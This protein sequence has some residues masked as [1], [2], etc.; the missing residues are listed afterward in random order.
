MT[1]SRGV[2]FYLYRRSFNQI[3]DVVL[4]GE[5]SSS[6]SSSSEEDDLDVLLLEMAFAPKLE[7][8]LHI[9]LEDISDIDCEHM[10]R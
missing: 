3:L 1:V 8:G 2:I 10:F 5:S 4:Y 6:D 7:L 9:N